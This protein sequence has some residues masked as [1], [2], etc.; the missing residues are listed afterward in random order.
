MKKLIL[1]LSLTLTAGLAYGQ[2]TVLVDFE[3]VNSDP[4]GNWNT[5][6]SS[7]AS[8][9]SLIDTTGASSGVQISLNG[10][11]GSGQ[12]DAFQGRLEGPSW[13]TSGQDELNDRFFV[14]NNSTGFITLSGLNPNLVYNIELV[15]S[16]TSTTGQGN[17]NSAGDPPGYLRIVDANGVVNAF[18]GSDGTLLT[19][20]DPDADDAPGVDSSEVDQWAAW[21]TAYYGNDFPESSSSDFSVEGWLVW[22]SIAPDGS[23]SITIE[24]ATAADDSRASINAMQ[25]TAIPEPSTY[26]AIFGLGALGMIL[27]R[28]KMRK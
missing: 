1:L 17:F 25:I 8:N 21:S 28:R 18:N 23:D 20:N 19:G 12:S 11:S 3:D 22:S 2:Q 16:S 13:A 7:S 26:A 6:G 15:S 10:W 4:G 14:G 9:V 27:L 24:F 5:I